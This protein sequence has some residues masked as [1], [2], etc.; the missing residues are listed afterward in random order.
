MQLL[1]KHG[2]SSKERE[3]EKHKKSYDHEMQARHGRERQVHEEIIA[4]LMQGGAPATPDA[5]ARAYD[6][7]QQLP[8]SV[9]RP[10]SS[11]PSAKKSISD[12]QTSSKDDTDDPGHG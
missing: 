11:V 9:V 8:G 5:Y 3:R 6:Q 1:S 4:R 2:E 12:A 7:W 10:P